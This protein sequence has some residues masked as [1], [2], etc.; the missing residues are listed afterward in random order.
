M[1]P[2]FIFNALNSI[3]YL[4]L[5]KQTERSIDYLSKFASL[6]RQ[7]MDNQKKVGYRSKM[8]SIS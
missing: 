1:N 7:V 8:K 2:H 5:E 6:L 4:I 3:Q